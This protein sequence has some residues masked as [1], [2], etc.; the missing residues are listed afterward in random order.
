LAT[1]VRQQEIRHSVG[2]GGRLEIKVTDADVRVRAAEGGEVRLRAT[3]ELAAGSEEEA[4]RAFEL[5]K[6]D[7]HEG[8][9]SLEVRDRRERGELSGAVRRLLTGSGRI[10]LSIEGEAPP[11]ADLRLETVSGDVAVEGMRAGQRYTTV[12]GDLF[13]TDLAGDLR[14]TTVSGDATMRA[15][16][17]I[18]IRAEGVSGDISIIAP[19]LDGMRLTTVSGDLEVEAQLDRNGEHRMETVSG[20]VSFGLVGGATFDVRGLSTDISA[21]VDHRVEGRADRR[22]VII[23][24][25]IP[26]VVFSSMSGDIRIRRPRR[27]AST[28]PEAASSSQPGLA[29]PR[30]L[31]IL[32]AL[33]RGEIDVD[34]ATRRLEGGDDA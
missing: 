31:E 10:S 29:S 2:P 23:G 30:S 6:L 9:E 4:D 7:V 19:R 17:P 16:A 26:S 25:G 20:D 28:A 34:E 21:E 3:F 11:D 27:L 5:A 24:D 22:R 18:L 33:E 15:Q 8:D 14:L 13:L 32:R 1:Y 12:S